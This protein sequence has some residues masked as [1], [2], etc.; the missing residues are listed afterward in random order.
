[1]RFYGVLFERSGE[2]L[3]TVGL[4]AS[5]EAEALERALAILA[6]H[7][8]GDPREG[9]ENVAVRVGNLVRVDG[10]YQIVCAEGTFDV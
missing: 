10:K 4:H 2:K 5:N 6:E 9:D 8:D 1:M 3:A 7:G